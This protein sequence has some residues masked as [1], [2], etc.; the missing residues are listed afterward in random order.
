VVVS[1]LRSSTRSATRRAGS[2]C[3][4]ATRVSYKPPSTAATLAIRSLRK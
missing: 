1:R 2:L 4:Q 3:Q